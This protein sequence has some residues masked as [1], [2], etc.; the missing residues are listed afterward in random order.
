LDEAK[1]VGHLVTVFKDGRNSGP[2]VD[3]STVTEDDII[4]MMVGRKVEEKYPKR[5]IQIG[6][7]VFR[8]E[9][10][11]SL[12]FKDISFNVRKGE[13]L[14]IFGLVGAGRT[15]L[16]RSIFGADPL[17]KGSIF[18]EGKKVSIKNSR[19][20]IEK[21]IVL[22]TENRKE[23][24]LVLIHNV[25]ENATIVTLKDFKNWSLINNNKRDKTV[26]EYGN[27]LQLRPVDPQMNAMNFSGGNQQKIVIMKWII[28]GAKLFI[29]DE[30]TKGVDVGA[31]IE[32]Y[33]IINQLLEQG[34]SII[35]ISSEIPEIMGM[36]DRIMTIYEGIQTG[37]IDNNENVNQEM[38][39][40]MATRKS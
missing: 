2:T 15:E 28:A 30:P 24:G 40:S 35:M 23:E 22:I 37:I 17:L 33:T 39:L 26:F 7:E 27:M 8:G 38:I 34:A 19:S 16:A 32:I 25:R 6:E 4:T 20:A 3:V 18:V 11:G 9:H 12:K 31:K 29:F 10:L 21:G 5:N 14:G 36:S 13:L 1:K